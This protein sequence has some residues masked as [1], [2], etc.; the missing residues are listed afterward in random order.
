MGLH[1]SVAAA[2]HKLTEAEEPLV[3]LR[4]RR[5]VFR[6]R[7]TSALVSAYRAQGAPKAPRARLRVRPVSRR[8]GPRKGLN[9]CPVG[10]PTSE[11]AKKSAKPVPRFH[12]ACVKAQ[13]AVSAF[14]N[15]EG[16]VVMPNLC[17]NRL[18]V[19]G[20]TDMVE[21]FVTQTAI[22]PPDYTPAHR[23]E[24]HL[25]EQIKRGIDPIEADG[26]WPTGWTRS[27]PD[28]RTCFQVAKRRGFF[29]S[30]SCGPICLRPSVMRGWRCGWSG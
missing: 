9:G 12:I 24:L 10:G 13:S 14:R 11:Q 8:S 29:R 22:I 4:E 19:V 5:A 26:A 1:L 23:L 6:V 3:S 16:P 25:V 7:I 17:L 21:A 30:T 15:Q 18:H 2:H 28:G 27:A 20:A